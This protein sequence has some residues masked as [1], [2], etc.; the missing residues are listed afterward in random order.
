MATTF[1]GDNLIIT[2][3]AGGALHT[4][5]AEVDLYSD[6]KEWVK[7]TGHIYEPAFDTT[8]GDPTTD[9]QSVAA[10][11]FLRNDL[12][13]RIRPAEEDAEI[14]IDGNLFP[15][16]STL[17]IFVP[18]IGPFTVSISI[19]RSVNALNLSADLLDAF[20]LQQFIAFQ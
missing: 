19:D 13:W 6:W 15:R 10:Y 1:D 7:T 14:T 17:P 3:N 5:D 8:G 11:Y 9:T 16:Q 2:L 18:T 4:V 12:G 20:T